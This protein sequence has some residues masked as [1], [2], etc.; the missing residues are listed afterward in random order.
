MSWC[1]AHFTAAGMSSQ[2]NQSYSFC[3][4]RPAFYQSLKSKVGLAAAKAAA[5]RII[6][7]KSISMSR[8]VNTPWSP[9]KSAR[10]HLSLIRFGT[11]R[12]GGQ[13]CE[14]RGLQR[15]LKPGL[16]TETS[17][18]AG[19]RTGIAT[20]VLTEGSEVHEWHGRTGE[21]RRPPRRQHSCGHAQGCFRLSVRGRAHQHAACLPLVTWAIL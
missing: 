10:W 16:D 17:P 9:C 6:S 21:T 12:D 5:L 2:H 18:C 14:L 11:L 20:A 4:K 7:F 8:T 1:P 15:E 3:F 13:H 19:N